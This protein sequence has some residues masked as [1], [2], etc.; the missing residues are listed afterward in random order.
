MRNTAR[1]PRRNV[2]SKVGPFGYRPQKVRRVVCSTV[3][4]L[5]IIRGARLKLIPRYA[6]ALTRKLTSTINHRSDLS[7]VYANMCFARLLEEHL[8]S[9][10]IETRSRAR[11]RSFIKSADNFPREQNPRASYKYNSDRWDKALHR[12]HFALPY[13]VCVC[14]VIGRLCELTGQ[15]YGARYIVP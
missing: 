7:V 1:I 5:T 15:V 12:A 13:R 9:P 10:G 11:A 3:I 4:Q 14:V 6:R 2:L 8:A